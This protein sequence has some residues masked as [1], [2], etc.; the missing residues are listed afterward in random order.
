MPLKFVCTLLLSILIKLMGPFSRTQL[1]ISRVQRPCRTPLPFLSLSLFP[2]RSLS[3]SF[4]FVYAGWLAR[5]FTHSVSLLS[6]TF[7]RSFRLEWLVS[8]VLFICLNTMRFHL[9]KKPT[10]DA[11]PP[12]PQKN[13]TLNLICNF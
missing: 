9:K 13:A 8:Y 5:S 10:D 11:Y 12:P 2:A 3:L 4:S 1:T 6:L 7:F